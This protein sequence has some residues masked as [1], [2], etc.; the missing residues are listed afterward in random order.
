VGRLSLKKEMI[1]ESIRFDSDSIRIRY[2]SIRIRYDSIRIH[3]DSIRIR[4]DSIRF[5]SDSIR[6]WYDSIRFDSDSIRSNG[7]S[8]FNDSDSNES[9]SNLIRFDSI[10]FVRNTTPD[11]AVSMPLACD[12]HMT[13]KSRA[14][15]DFFC[16]ECIISTYSLY[17]GYMETIRSANLILNLYFFKF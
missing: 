12:H 16:F 4:Y 17:I 5:D 10:R 14:S 1:C 15:G 13:I 8:N 9:N 3:Y 2:D 6:I 11:L 7:E